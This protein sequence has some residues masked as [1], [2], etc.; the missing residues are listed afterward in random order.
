MIAHYQPQLKLSHI[1]QGRLITICDVESPPA[2][3]VLTQMNF[4]KEVISIMS[5]LNWAT[6][7]EEYTPG[8]Y[9]QSDGH[10]LSF[11]TRMYVVLTMADANADTPKSESQR[12]RVNK[13]KSMASALTQTREELFAGEFD[14][15]V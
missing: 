10:S 8:T 12:S 2:Y 4:S 13:R 3:P 11:L 6:A 9:E 1:G 15:F 7:D 14:G 5:S